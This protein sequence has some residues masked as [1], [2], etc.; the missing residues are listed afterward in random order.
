MNQ[1]RGWWFESG[2]KLCEFKEL[3]TITQLLFLY[4]N[5][6]FFSQLSHVIILS[7]LC[8]KLPKIKNKQKDYRE[9]FGARSLNLSNAT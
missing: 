8:M 9:L 7:I 3:V 1:R 2:W 4:A 5:V 6:F